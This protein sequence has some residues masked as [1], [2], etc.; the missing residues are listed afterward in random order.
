MYD[1]AQMVYAVSDKWESAINILDGVRNRSYGYTPNLRMEL[2]TARYL[3]A[4]V[5]EVLR[6]FREL[7][8]S[9]YEQVAEVDGFGPAAEKFK[10]SL[11][12][13][14][15]YWNTWVQ[16]ENMAEKV[17][18]VK[19]FDGASSAEL[20]TGDSSE[21]FLMQLSQPKGET[22]IVTLA[23]LVGGLWLLSVALSR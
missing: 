1:Q 13:A 15:M 11:A 8:R 20:A 3:A 12:N 18:L 19:A 14:K 2:D 5:V 16:S 6:R 10:A 17:E 4:T 7:S 23:A 9:G 21:S 22:E